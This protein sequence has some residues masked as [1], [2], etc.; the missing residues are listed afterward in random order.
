[1]GLEQ[2]ALQAGDGNDSSLVHELTHI[3]FGVS[4]SRSLEDGLCDCVQYRVGMQRFIWE[5]RP[6]WSVAEAMKPQPL[7]YQS[8]APVSDEKVA[9]GKE[10]V[11][12][13][14]GYS[15]GNTPTGSLWYVYSQYF[16]EYL[17]ETYG[18]ERTLS[19]IRLGEDE[20][21]YREYLGK[22]FKEVKA[23]WY[24]W[25]DKM[26]PSMTIEGLNEIERAYLVNYK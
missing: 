25:L 8:R 13:A 24:T 10:T 14:Q 18:M 22:P 2:R 12:M 26:E 6:D 21:A 7:Y 19:L 5:A 23:D 20:G 15:Y 16:V 4:F 1:M 11:G 9:E 17:V 3:I